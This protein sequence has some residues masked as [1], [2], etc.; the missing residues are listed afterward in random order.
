MHRHWIERDPGPANVCPDTARNAP[1][2]LSIDH[3]DGLA[4][5]RL[6]QGLQL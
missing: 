4:A 3:G 1:K 2:K 6:D 5:A